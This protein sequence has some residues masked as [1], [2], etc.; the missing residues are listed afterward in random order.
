[1]GAM[2]M[3]LPSNFLRVDHVVL[4]VR[5]NEPDV[6]NP[7]RIVDP[8]HQPILIARYIKD[9]AAILEDTRAADRPLHVRRSCPVRC[10]GLSIPSHQWLTWVVMSTASAEDGLERTKRY[11]P[12]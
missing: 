1:M 12:H 5:S 4:S 6:N 8:H 11:D 3:F 7:V 10:L 2:S 9:H